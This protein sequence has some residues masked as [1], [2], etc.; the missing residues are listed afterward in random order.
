MTYKIQKLNLFLNAVM[1]DKQN[2]VQITCD[3]QNAFKTSW[4]LYQL[5]EHLHYILLS[6]CYI[7]TRINIQNYK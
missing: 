6:V 3:I 7:I 1:I 4:H 5:V 2:C